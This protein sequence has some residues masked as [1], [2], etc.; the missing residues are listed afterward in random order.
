MF[1]GEDALG[2]RV[3]VVGVEDRDGALQDDGAVVEVFVDEVDGATRDFDAV[4][5]GLLLSVEAGE[6]GQQRRV[7]IEDAV[8][9]GGNELGR[10]QAHIAGEDDEVDAVVAEGGGDVGVVDFS[11]SPFGDV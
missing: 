11:R 9:E 4:V 3:G 2:E 7:D 6:G 8:G 1:F 5:E 10:E